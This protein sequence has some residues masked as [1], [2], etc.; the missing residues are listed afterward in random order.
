MKFIPHV[1]LPIWKNLLLAEKQVRERVE[2]FISINGTESVDSFH[3]R[4]GKIMW[5][6]C[7]MARNAEGLKKA[8]TLIP[9]L[10][11]EFWKNV[12]VTGGPDYFN[13]E[14]EKAGYVADFLE[15]GELIVRDALHREESCGGHFREEHQTKEGE[16]LRDD[17]DFAYVG[18]LGIQG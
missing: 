7:G 1:C 10:R 2:K 14:I 3:K 16:A 12:R 15:M 8:L 5:D 11:K 18:S 13:P 17:L 4:L 6:Y 9:E